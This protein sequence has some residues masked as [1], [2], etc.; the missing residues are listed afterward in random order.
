MTSYTKRF[1]RRSSRLSPQPKIKH[2]IQPHTSGVLVMAP[3]V[4][5]LIPGRV[6]LFVGCANDEMGATVTVAARE[7]RRA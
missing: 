2:E 3:G 6:T 1:E 4:P 5:A 7:E